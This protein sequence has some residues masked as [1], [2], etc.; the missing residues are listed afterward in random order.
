MKRGRLNKIEQ[1]LIDAMETAQQ[2][3]KGDLEMNHQGW[4]EEEH[5]NGWYAMDYRENFGGVFPIDA[6]GY[7]KPLINDELIEKGN[8]DVYRC[9]AKCHVYVCG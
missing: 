2:Y 8:V 4:H 6:N 1:A 7:D 9:F 5:L 3:C